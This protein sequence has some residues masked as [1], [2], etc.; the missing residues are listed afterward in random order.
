MNSIRVLLVDDHGLVRAGIK[1]LIDQIDGFVVVAEANDG[2]E[3]L[4]LI[5][6]NRVS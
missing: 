6:A 2:R 3:A 4:E 5:Q 1:S